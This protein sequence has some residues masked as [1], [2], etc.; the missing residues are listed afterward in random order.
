MVIR[1]IE[2]Y[3]KLGSSGQYDLREVYVNPAHVVAIRQDLRSSSLLE[4]KQLPE[5]LIPHQEFTTLYL[6]D[7]KSTLHVVG[8]MN[9]IKEKLYKDTRELLKG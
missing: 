5:G 3:D 6:S 1:L 2:L 9:Y 4:G 8:D 7:H